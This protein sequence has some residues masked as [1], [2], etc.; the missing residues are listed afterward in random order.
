MLLMGG[1]AI[2]DAPVHSASYVPSCAQSL[3]SVLAWKRPAG[4]LE[5]TRPPPPDAACQALASAL[6]L[7]S[8]RHLPRAHWMPRQDCTLRLSGLG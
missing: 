7:C 6:H 8:G 4:V 5:R 3:H 1:C 2:T